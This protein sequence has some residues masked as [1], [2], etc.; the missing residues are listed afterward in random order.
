MISQ[1][2]EALRNNEQYQIGRQKFGDNATANETAFQQLQSMADEL[3]LDRNILNPPKT[4]QD[5]DEYLTRGIAT[6]FT[7]A[8]GSGK[9][10]EQIIGAANKLSGGGALPQVQQAQNVL[11]QTQEAAGE[12]QVAVDELNRQLTPAGGFDQPTR[13]FGQLIEQRGGTAGEGEQPVGSFGEQDDPELYTAL[14]ESGMKR[15]QIRS[16]LRRL[17]SQG[18][19]FTPTDAWKE[20]NSF[21]KAKAENN[22]LAEKNKL[23]SETRIKED[24]AQRVLSAPG[25][26]QLF[27]A[28]GNQVDA[29]T[30]Q[31]MLGLGI[32]TG[33]QLAKPPTTVVQ[34]GGGR[35]APTAGTNAKVFAELQ[36]KNNNNQ[37]QLT[38]IA[39]YIADPKSK[40]GRDIAAEEGFTSV[41]QAHQTQRRLLKDIVKNNTL[42]N[43]LIPK[44]G[45]ELPEETETPA[46][47]R[48]PLSS[49][50]K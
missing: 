34:T 9:T 35:G 22:A 10:Q 14:I 17:A 2:P 47:E 50:Q 24:F 11:T 33:E 48:K 12:R 27:D 18:E 31:N 16:V 13:P 19:K 40:V 6:L 8:Q 5:A 20:V 46:G 39:Q 44:L 36:K 45:L 28:E 41:T 3:Q 29:V 42:I 21:L 37:T 38:R 23:E 25:V 49:F 30:L 15:V 26:N 43:Q 1:L 32:G 4:D 7:A